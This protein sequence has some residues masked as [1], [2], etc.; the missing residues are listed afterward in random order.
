MTHS[1]LLVGQPVDLYVLQIQLNA[2]LDSSYSVQ[3]IHE[4][5]AI[6]PGVYIVVFNSITPLITSLYYNL[7]IDDARI[8]LPC[9]CYNVSFAEKSKRFYREPWPWRTKGPYSPNIILYKRTARLTYT[10]EWHE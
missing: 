7:K 2:M 10:C 3:C 6:F 4:I 5:I 8:V 1:L 9:G